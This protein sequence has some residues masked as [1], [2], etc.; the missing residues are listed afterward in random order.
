M[1]HH[2]EIT[3][4]VTCNINYKSKEIT[5]NCCDKCFHCKFNN[6]MKNV[7]DVTHYVYNPHIDY[8]IK[9]MR[10]IF[11]DVPELVN[12]CVLAT[13]DT[14]A[15][16]DHFKNDHADVMDIKSIVITH[17][18]YKM[19]RKYAV[20]SLEIVQY[21]YVNVKTVNAIIKDAVNSAKDDNSEEDDN[22]TINSDDDV[23]DTMT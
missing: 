8:E 3:Q 1:S 4:N 20:I 21:K 9:G 14:P 13:L 22:S 17:V 7:L 19:F 10:E 18:D 23:D 2:Y 15:L 11:R 6:L 16:R 5:L 12:K